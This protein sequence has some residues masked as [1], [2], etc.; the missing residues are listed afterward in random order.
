MYS[1]GKRKTKTDLI[2]SENK[3]N[4]YVDEITCQEEWKYNRLGVNRGQCNILEA[5]RKQPNRKSRRVN[6]L[7]D[8]DDKRKTPMI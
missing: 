5:K 1:D 8:S 2:Y 6:R 3:G 7:L 4:I